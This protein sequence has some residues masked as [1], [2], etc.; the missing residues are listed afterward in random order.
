MSTGF[1]SG[2]TAYVHGVALVEI[3]FPIDSKGTEYCCCEQCFYFRE[4]SRSCALNHETIA[5]PS[6][7]VG[8]NCPLI[9]VTPEQY[10]EIN[11][12]ILNISVNGD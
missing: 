3:Y 11:R 12:T 9:R 10:D 1:E 8:D 2:V 5:F 7:Y 6:R 4:A